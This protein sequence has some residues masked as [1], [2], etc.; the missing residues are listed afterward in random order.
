[1]GQNF[2]N[3]QQVNDDNGLI[4]KAFTTA[5]GS[6]LTRNGR[7][8]WFSS[9]RSCRVVIDLSKQDDRKRAEMLQQAIKK[10]NNF[11]IVGE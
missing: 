5:D 10:E 11:D 9:L 7:P 3:S 8:K 1:V 2:R 6:P 4:Y